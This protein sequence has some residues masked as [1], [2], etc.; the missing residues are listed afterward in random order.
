MEKAFTV[1]GNYWRKNA[2]LTPLSLLLQTILQAFSLKF[3]RAKIK[4]LPYYRKL[5]LV[6]IK[7]FE[8][9]VT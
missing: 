6:I 1:Y 2:N 3:Y 9:N 4:V 5:T 7:V 8:I